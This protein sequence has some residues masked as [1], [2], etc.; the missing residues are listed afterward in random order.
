ML[1]SPPERSRPK[2]PISACPEVEDDEGGALAGLAAMTRVPVHPASS[3]AVRVRLSMLSTPCEVS[4]SRAPHTPGEQ[5]PRGDPCEP[6]ERREYAERARRAE[7]ER[8]QAS[9]EQ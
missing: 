3:A 5:Q 4:G 8:V 6:A 2:L 7:G 9:R 1:G